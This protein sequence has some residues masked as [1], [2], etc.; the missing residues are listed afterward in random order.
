MNEPLPTKEGWKLEWSEVA[1]VAKEVMVVWFIGSE[2]EW[3]ER[4]W[5][6]LAD[7][8]LTRY[9]ND[10]ER[11]RVLMRFIALAMIYRD[12][13]QLGREEDWD[14]DTLIGEVI[15][16]LELSRIRIGQVIGP[17]WDAD[18]LEETDDDLTNSAI[19]E[20]TDSERAVIATVLVKGFGSEVALAD[21]LCRTSRID[22]AP[23]EEDEHEKRAL[24]GLNDEEFTTAARIYEWVDQGMKRL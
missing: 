2:L 14:A 4:A 10:I 23:D 13:C 21:A 7:A 24:K 12:F 1:S 20:L 16:G 5:G 18:T 22:A 11:T 6:M 15:Y 19:L 17:E 3:A 9:A 8:G